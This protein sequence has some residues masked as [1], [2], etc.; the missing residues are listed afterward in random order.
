M[1][2]LF[3]AM[4]LLLSLGAP[5]AAQIRDADI[6]AYNKAFSE[7]DDAAIA[8][9]ASVLAEAAMSDPEHPDA[10]LIAF[11]TAWA[12]CRLNRC[13]DAIRPAEWAAARTDAPPHAGLALAF[14]RW[15]TDA[16]R[17]N[18]KAL[19]AAIEAAT[20][21]DPSAVSLSAFRQTYLRDA[22]S[23]NFRNAWKTAALAK[24]HFARGGDALEEFAFEAELVEIANLNNDR[25]DIRHQRQ[26]A[27]LAGRL[28]RLEL[29]RGEAA[30]NWIEQTRWRAEAWIL[31]I[32]AL[33][34]SLGRD[35][36]SDSQ[37][38][39]LREAKL[40]GAPEPPSE[41]SD[42]RPFC[43]G[44]LVQM[45]PLEYPQAALDRHQ[46]G[47]VIARFK[48]A[49]GKVADAEVLAA[50]PYEGFKEEALKTLA[51]WT[52]KVAPGQDLSTCRLSRKNI[53]IPFVF[54]LR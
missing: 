24:D 8:R 31:A 14:A 37:I 21:G 36:L 32:G 1:R 13:S 52:W 53:I 44:Q 9:T 40:A 6:A 35:S 18:R 4:V 26:M 22:G 50:V 43:E 41:P 39:G 27:D 5:A 38:A 7:R 2:E 49:D 29:I 11:E 12:L 20:Q 30:G 33:L 42:P 25:P 48:V 23:G 16:S 45:P 28:W 46:V 54:T 15:R 51:Q 3:F 19:D 47:A 34:D 10:S 17:A